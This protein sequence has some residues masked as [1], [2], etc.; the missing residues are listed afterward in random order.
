MPDP[1]SS[2][3]STHAEA[4]A[5]GPLEG[6]FHEQTPL[7]PAAPPRWTQVDLPL[8]D[9]ALQCLPKLDA[10]VLGAFS[11]IPVIAALAGIKAG[12]ELFECADG[13][14]HA[15]DLADFNARATETCLE[16]GGT[17]LGVRGNEFE[18]E[19]PRGAR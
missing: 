14:Q 19:G 2:R 4:T 17:P 15:A 12:Y 11:R 16:R 8:S 5:S 3:P 13:V 6:V 18:C 1:V 9:L 7:A 10:V